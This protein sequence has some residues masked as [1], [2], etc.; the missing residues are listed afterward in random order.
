MSDQQEVI[1]TGNYQMVAQQGDGRVVVLLPKQQMTRD[2]ALLHAA[3]IVAIC[4][5]EHNEFER[6]LTAVMNT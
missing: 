3:W 2:E 4:A 5:P 1:D 6:V